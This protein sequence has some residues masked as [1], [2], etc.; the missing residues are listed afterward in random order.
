MFS[1]S[2]LKSFKV[3][4]SWVGSSIS[5]AV[6]PTSWN[7]VS[8][9]MDDYASK[10]DRTEMHNYMHHQL[11]SLHHNLLRRFDLF[12]ENDNQ[13]LY[14]LDV[15]KSSLPPSISLSDLKSQ[16]DFASYDFT[17]N[18]I[19]ALQIFETINNWLMSMASLPPRA[20]THHPYF[21]GLEPNNSGTFDLST[22]NPSS[23]RLFFESFE[24]IPPALFF[25]GIALTKIWFLYDLPKLLNLVTNLL[26]H[27][28][29]LSFITVLCTAEGLLDLWT[30]VKMN[31]EIR[32]K[33]MHLRLP[34]FDQWNVVFS[35]FSILQILMRS[36]PDTRAIE[37][38]R[39]CFDLTMERMQFVGAVPEKEFEVELDEI[40]GE[41]A[42]GIVRKMKFRGKTYVV[43]SIHPVFDPTGKEK[44]RKKGKKE[45][46][47]NIGIG[48]MKYME[49]Y[50]E[51]TESAQ[52]WQWL[53]RQL[54]EYISM[55]ALPREGFVKL[56][57][58]YVGNW[59]SPPRRYCPNCFT[60]KY[61]LSKKKKK[62]I[63]E[64]KKK[65]VGEVEENEVK[66]VYMKKVEV[67]IL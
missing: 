56:Y 31:S 25:H 53:Y 48:Y 61:D 21:S 11:S 66:V 23:I 63:V 15:L 10:Q 37:N 43:K 2:S 17:L 42:D 9:W 6:T 16:H 3:I 67:E 4:P 7:F 14:E 27:H 8:S 60:N 64:D 51:K 19:T 30:I 45:N 35:T 41:G 36:F 13:L 62:I 29:D 49:E 12:T 1:S 58:C 20:S 24:Q 22:W 26:Y 40:L 32:D 47:G 18:T 44:E 59:P 57:Y 50:G 28:N 34:S 38:F 39:F 33:L 52:L 5:A 46:Y 54:G 55:L 65:K